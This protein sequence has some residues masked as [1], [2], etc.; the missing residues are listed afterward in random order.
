MNSLTQA[1]QKDKQSWL[2]KA[3]HILSF[4]TCPETILTHQVQLHRWKKNWITNIFQV[5]FP[6][7]PNKNGKMKDKKSWTRIWWDPHHPTLLACV[8]YIFSDL[9]WQFH[10]NRFIR[11]SALLLTGEICVRDKV[12]WH[13]LIIWLGHQIWLML[14][15]M[16]RAWFRG[17]YQS[18]IIWWDLEQSHWFTS[19]G[20]FRQYV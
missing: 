14:S 10:Q 1:A 16:R 12:Q 18:R 5:S 13:S 19:C 6:T 8:H 4:L 9:A 7:I 20:L 17:R 2:Q 11:F 3:N 15:I